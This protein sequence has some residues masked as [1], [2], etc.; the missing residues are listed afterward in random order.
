MS[1]HTMHFLDICAVDATKRPEAELAAKPSKGAL[2]ARL[3]DMDKKGDRVSYLMALMEKVSDTRDGLSDTELRA[4]II[5]DVACMRRFFLNASV[6][7]P[8]EFLLNYFDQ[9]RRRPVERAKLAY[10][11]FLR[12]ANDRFKLANP[13]LRKRRIGLVEELV[14]AADGLGIPRQHT[15]HIMTLARLFGNPAAIKVMKFKAEAQAFDAENV[16]ADI[17][18]IGRFLERKLE[19]EKNWRQGLSD[20]RHATYVTDDVGLQE[21]L[22]CYEGHSISS[23][24]FDG[25]H[26]VRINGR[27]ELAKLLTEI[28]HEA[29]PILDPAE[30][31]SAGPSEYDRVCALLLAIP[32]GRSTDDSRRASP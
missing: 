28:S 13:V 12:I 15:V 14:A 3:R 6:A 26:E 23:R 1:A 32:P 27:V 17:M 7:E 18:T 10:L 19:L 21:I 8:D 24:D 2:V 22:A 30:G 4:N 20:F 11:E 5:N 31:S 9:L 16:L 25:H 29:G